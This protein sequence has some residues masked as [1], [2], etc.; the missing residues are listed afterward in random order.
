MTVEEQFAQ[1]RTEMAA[2]NAQIAA[3]FTSLSE[4][5]NQ[6][7]GIATNAAR[8]AQQAGGA[9][10]SMATWAQQAAAAGQ[11]SITPGPVNL[12]P[13]HPP[14]F[15][16][17]MKEPRILEWTHLAS[18][19]L[20]AANLTESVQGVFHI[21]NYLAE[22]AAVW[23]RLYCARVER[24]ESPAVL[25]WW[26][27]RMLLLE[28]FSEINR[29]TSIRD[30]FANLRQT[31]SVASYIT[32]FQSIVL[33][34][35]DKS[36]DEQVHAFLRG[37]KTNVAVHTRTHQ[38]PTLVAAMRIADEADRA[39]YLSGAHRSDGSSYSKPRYTQPSRGGN[40]SGAKSSGPAPMQLG[41]VSLSP[42][43]M[44]RCQREGLCFNCQKPGHQ[45]RNCTAGKG[46]GGQ[47]GRGRGKPRP[48]QG[49]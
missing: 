27:L 43:Q 8:W 29:L 18:Q 2:S 38:P 11:A 40:G 48:G 13:P 5:V 4:K 34:L 10:N 14:K 35:P 23:W 3:A 32:K 24:G 17:T 33:E 15:K 47:K 28:Q 21:T 26:A 6:A 7:G 25:N 30:Q 19:F 36:E 37:L 42:A 31:G 45:S 16:G 1:L 46:A 41:A 44:E 12:K 22:D 20:M 39:M 9:A 49:N